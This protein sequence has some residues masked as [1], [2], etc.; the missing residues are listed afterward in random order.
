[1]VKKWIIIINKVD[2]SKKIIKNLNFDFTKI[3]Y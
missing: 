3:A 1:M 2:Y